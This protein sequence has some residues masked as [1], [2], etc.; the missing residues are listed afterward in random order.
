MNRRRFTQGAMATIASISA[1]FAWR[2]A[3]ATDYPATRGAPTL[4]VYSTTDTDVFEPVI[5]DFQAVI[6]GVSVR[7]EELDAGELHE[8][9][10]REATSG[11]ESADLLLSSA[12]DLQ[13]KLVNDGFATPHRSDNALALPS[14]A[15]W[16][17][18]ALGFTFEPAVMVFNRSALAGRQLPQ[19]RA[20]LLQMLLHEPTLWRGRVGTYDIARSSVGYLLASQDVRLSSEFGALLEA[21]GNVALRT[22]IRTADLLDRI[23]SG[24]LY[25]GYNLLG[26]YALTRVDAGAPIEIVYPD[27]YT[28]AVTRTAVIPASA[29][30]PAQAHE[31][32]EY[33]LSVRGQ[34]TMAERSRLPA[35]RPELAA[36]GKRPGAVDARI[37]SLRPIP[38]GP[39]LLVYLDRQKR[40]RM[41]ASWRSILR[42][43]QET[44]EVAH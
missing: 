12:M 44:E 42:A 29:T 7:Y 8:R 6:P 23:A 32:L 36:S 31:F 37:G 17:A 25:V 4:R 20:E 24:E 35:V 41:L 27:D 22:E 39:G 2:P 18:E 9:F 1:G 43:A 13:V 3:R 16:R 19:S 34:Q 10:L 14:W 21:F 30:H 11:A 15:Q 38:L 33:L 40:E 28:L 26:S 5:R